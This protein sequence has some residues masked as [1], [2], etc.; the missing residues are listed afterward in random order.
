MKRA[1]LLTLALLPA[2]AAALAC[3]QPRTPVDASDAD[4]GELTCD[5]KARVRV[6]CQTALQQRCE[7]QA[8]QCDLG[9]GAPG[10]AMPSV[11]ANPAEN[12]PQIVDIKITQCRDNCRHGRDACVGTVT[13]R[14]P[15]PCQ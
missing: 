5:E 2:L 10:G 1:A 9:C 3:G 11:P 13:Q 15:V 7:S 8:N 12:A 14:C 6:M 4:G